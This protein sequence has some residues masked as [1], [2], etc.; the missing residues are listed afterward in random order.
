MQQPPVVLWFK[1]YAAAMVL[2]Y[3]VCAAL[4]VA[5]VLFGH[6]YGDME[7][8]E[9]IL[10]GGVFTAF[11]GPLILIYGAA[12]FLPRKSWVWIYDLVLICG[13]FTGCCTLPF[14]IALLIFWIKPE[15]KAYFGRT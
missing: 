7:A 13:G 2:L 6:E 3:I 14:S 9:A 8:G 5:I 1:V 15:T 4:G 10:V 12:L 11:S